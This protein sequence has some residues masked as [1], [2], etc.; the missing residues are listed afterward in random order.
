MFGMTVASED[1]P[2]EIVRP[3]TDKALVSLHHKRPTGWVD[4]F[5]I[6]I[7]K[8]NREAVTSER[9]DRGPIQKTIWMPGFISKIRKALASKSSVPERTPGLS[10]SSAECGPCDEADGP[11]SVI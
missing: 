10:R 8:F 6:G 9:K 1:K 4:Y 3:G 2:N 5:A 7:V 11:E